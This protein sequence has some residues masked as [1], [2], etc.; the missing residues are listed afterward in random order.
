[1]LS[2]S[3]QDTIAY[4]QSLEKQETPQFP[5]LSRGLHSFVFDN[6]SMNYS[7]NILVFDS[8][9]FC[10]TMKYLDYKNAFIALPIVTTVQGTN[11][12]HCTSASDLMLCYKNSNLNLIHSVAI[13]LNGVQIQ[14]NY[15][16]S[17]NLLILKKHLKT[18]MESQRLNGAFD[19]YYPDSDSWGFSGQN[20][21]VVT[22]NGS[23]YGITNNRNLPSQSYSSLDNTNFYNE[24][25]RRRQDRFA[26]IVAANNRNMIYNSATK[27]NQDYIQNDAGNNCKVYYYTA[28][29]KLKDLSSIFEN[30]PLSK[31]VNFRISLTLNNN[32]SFKVT[33]SITNV[34]GALTSSTLTQSNFS[35]SSSLTNPIMFAAAHHDILRKNALFSEIADAGGVRVPLLKDD[36]NRF[37]INTKADETIPQGSCICAVLPAGADSVGVAEYTIT[38]NLCVSSVRNEYKHTLSSTRLYVPTVLMSPSYEQTYT[39]ESNL[40]RD[41]EYEEVVQMTFNCAAGEHVQQLLTSGLTRLSSLILIPYLSNT[42]NGNGT[43]VHQLSSAFDS[44]PSTTAPCVITNFNVMVGVNPIFQNAINYSFENFI[45]SSN[46]LWGINSNQEDFCIGQIDLQKFSSNYSYFIT[47][48]DRRAPSEEQMSN[49]VSVQLT[50]STLKDL[51]FFAYL[52]RKKNFQI[53]VLT[54]QRKD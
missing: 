37:T 10:S 6:S 46:G 51:T 14:T 13:E 42:A 27:S 53:N 15:G 4:N 22:P 39:S 38:Q 47:N 43:S 28:Y 52:I 1:M 33:R 29:I 11:N 8:L 24:G 7:S 31:L 35:N 34:G 3:Q 30:M 9:S 49:S 54:G 21:G 44:A 32:L 26:S 2:A 40:I 50:N 19:N 18:S 36:D 12:V 48:L 45:T 17:N 41:I 23:G 25:M 20:A 5:F 16:Y